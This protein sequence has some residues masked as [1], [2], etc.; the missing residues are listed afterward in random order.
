MF[1]FEQ[2]DRTGLGVAERDARSQHV[3]KPGLER[4]GMPKLYIGAPI[5]MVSAVFSSAISV[6]DSA[7]A[8]AC[9]SFAGAAPRN[10]VAESVFRCGIGF[11]PNR[12]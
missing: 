10:A 1:T 11:A 5:T 6:S 2:P 4:G 8:A 3:V 9:A 7:S 12:A